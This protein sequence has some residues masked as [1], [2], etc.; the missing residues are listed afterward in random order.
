MSTERE[1]R[2]YQDVLRMVLWGE[3]KDDVMRKLGVNGFAGDAADRLYARAFGER[4]AEIFASC[5]RKILIGMLMIASG[6]GLFCICWFVLR[7]TSNWV[8]ALS[9]MGLG[10]GTWKVIDGF[11]GILTAKTREGSVTDDD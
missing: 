2:V 3:P 7:F 8:I 11:A 4:L 6:V 1:D 9:A 10:F 5:R